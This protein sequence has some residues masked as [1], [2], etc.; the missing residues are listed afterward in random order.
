MAELKI[1]KK[2]GRI[3]DYNEEK[4]RKSLIKAGTSENDA[5]TI[6][7]KTTEWVREKAKQGAVE[8]SKIRGKV[9]EQLRTVNNQIAE[10]FRTFV[11]PSS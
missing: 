4:V 8:T 2:D 6:A 11:K 1:K 3:E 10:K 7:S 9:L 5:K